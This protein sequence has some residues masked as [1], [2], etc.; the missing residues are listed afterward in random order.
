MSLLAI[1]PNYAPLAPSP[2]CACGNAL[3]PADIDVCGD[4]VDA[5]LA[6]HARARAAG[7]AR[8]R[9][10]GAAAL[11]RTLLA[12]TGRGAHRR[13]LAARVALYDGGP[14]P[15][16]DHEA[17]VRETWLMLD[18]AALVSVPAMLVREGY[19]HGAARVLGECDPPVHDRSARRV[20]AALELAAATR[21]LFEGTRAAIRLAL[22]ASHAML[23]LDGLDEATQRAACLA[24]RAHVTALRALAHD[25]AEA[26]AAT[27]A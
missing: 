6:Q 17:F 18:R 3:R 5:E 8:R 23:G 1:V 16:S 10:D 22:D 24:A 15:A 26:F 9:I 11:A 20:I 21:F 4:C 13:A 7:A 19:V 25:H 14:L 27:A 12:V 2:S